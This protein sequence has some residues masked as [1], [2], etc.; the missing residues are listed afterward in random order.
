MICTS[1]WVYVNNHGG[2]ARPTFE[3]AKNLAKSGCEVTVIGF[4]LQQR[5]SSQ[6]LDFA[7][8]HG[9]KIEE[10]DVSKVSETR[11]FFLHMQRILQNRI[12][13]I[14]PNYVI[15]Q[16]WSSPLLLSTNLPDVKVVTWIHGGTLYDHEGNN[17]YFN[18]IYQAIDSELE[19]YQ[20]ERSSVVVSPS[21]F[22]VKYYKNH[23]WQLPLDSNVIPYHFPEAQ[24]KSQNFSSARLN[25]VFI[26]QLSYRKGFDVFLKTV[27]S[28]KKF[29]ADLNLH[30][31]IYG[32][33]A[34]F[35]GENACLIL[36]DLGISVDYFG[37]VDPKIMWK[38]IRS[39]KSIVFCTSRLDNSPNT[40]Y[41]SISN[42]V[43]S[44]IIGE[45]NGAIELTSYSNLL[46]V[47]CDLDIIDWEEILELLDLDSDAIESDVNSLVTKKWIDIFKEH[48]LDLNKTFE[49][50]RP[51]VSVVVVSCNR[52]DM[53]LKALRSIKDQDLIPDEVIIV[54]DASVN[55]E[56]IES[57]AIQEIP[58]VK[59]FQNSSSRGP[60]FSRN[61]GV[62]N[63]SSEL[64]AF[65]DDD[66]TYRSDHLSSSISKM[67]QLGADVIVPYLA[68]VDNE[69]KSMNRTA[70]FMG[71]ALH[72]LSTLVNTI[73]DTHFVA[74][75]ATFEENGGF[76]ELW[77]NSQEDWSLLLRWQKNNVRIE[78]SGLPTINYR[79]SQDGIQNS[80]SGFSS[81]D[82][83]DKFSPGASWISSFGMRM[84]I[85]APATYLVQKNAIRTFYS[86]LRQKNWAQI[87][88]GFKM[89]L[90][91]FRVLGGK[92]YG[93]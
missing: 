73:G 30:V 65:L 78:G 67:V 93:A 57:L 39:E 62:K 34:D 49:E 9:F 88:R 80:K 52:Q 53:L 54:D 64:V 8:Q 16:E 33:A 2:I 28:A 36:R 70:V 82:R 59:I 21:N 44:I 86:L 45:N 71:S 17:R 89:V 31:S 18:N 26:G 87:R 7:H 3:L 77:P 4:R 74:R 48:S 43:P 84:A 55:F 32:S 14:K 37:V 58:N 29:R 27:E 79:I 22:L 92:Y 60:G 35:S 38:N 41:E 50:P 81:W 10:L 13:E 5:L 91:D 90:K 85:Y 12:V 51:S 75:K 23:G 68:I 15:A 40:V 76:D 24:Q 56:Q 25:L 83:V 11:P 47:F 42:R 66:N 20:V 46:R 61:L 72:S 69:G 63:A 19:R 6:D 1:Q